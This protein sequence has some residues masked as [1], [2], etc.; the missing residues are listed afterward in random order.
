MST[1]RTMIAATGLA[2]VLGASAVA[3]VD[4]RGVRDRNVILLQQDIDRQN[5]LAA[6]RELSA[7]QNRYATQLTLRA[8]DEAARPP[9]QPTLR[10]SLPP[11]PPRGAS[12]ED[13]ADDMARMD[14][15]TDAA[16]AAGN[17]RLRAIKPA[18]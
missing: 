14:R 17:A 18:S 15:L 5:I 12:A 7:A 2:L 9:T 1:V 8:L 6:Q 11:S 3:Q 10:P 4:L 16:L 13:M